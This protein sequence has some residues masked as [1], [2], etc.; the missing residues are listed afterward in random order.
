MMYKFIYYIH[1]VSQFCVHSKGIITFM[2]RKYGINGVSGGYNTVQTNCINLKTPCAHKDRWCFKFFLSHIL[3]VTFMNCFIFLHII[4]SESVQN[5]NLFL[6]VEQK[7]GLYIYNLGI[8]AC[9]Q[10]WCLLSAYKSRVF[11]YHNCSICIF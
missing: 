6:V 2:Y 9:D 1:F 4:L 8:Y 11:S 5:Y 10:S 3:F 7:A